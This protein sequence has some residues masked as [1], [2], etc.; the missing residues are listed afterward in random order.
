MSRGKWKPRAVKKQV[1]CG[2]R[3]PNALTARPRP[4]ASLR[5]ALRAAS[6]LN[7]AHFAD[8]L[9]QGYAAQVFSD[10]LLGALGHASS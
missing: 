1:V 8:E 10:G 5:E 9:G 4:P 6:V 3:R 2:A 7:A